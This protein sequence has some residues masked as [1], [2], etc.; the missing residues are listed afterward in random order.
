MGTYLTITKA[1]LSQEMQPRQK[2]IASAA[3]LTA[4]M[5]LGRVIQVST[6]PYCKILDLLKVHKGAGSESGFVKTRGRLLPCSG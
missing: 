6:Y 3:A 2:I 4:V 1:D 5:V